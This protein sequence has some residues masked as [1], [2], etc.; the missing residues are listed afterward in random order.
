[1]F[2]LLACNVKCRPGTCSLK[3][4]LKIYYNSLSLLSPQEVTE[5]GLCS[6]VILKLFCLTRVKPQ[7]RIRGESQTSIVA[8]QDELQTQQN[9][10]SYAI[11]STFRS[12]LHNHLRME[13]NNN[14]ENRQQMTQGTKVQLD[15]VPMLAYVMRYL[16]TPEFVAL[17]A[18]AISHRVKQTLTASRAVQGAPVCVL[19]APQKNVERAIQHPHESGEIPVCIS[20]G[21]YVGRYATTGLST[22]AVRS[23]RLG[24]LLY[25][26]SPS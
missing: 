4:V 13:T 10:N 16:V 24:T 23:A 21:L 22:L 5:P 11:T 19:N 26:V 7:S 9:Q 2:I 18:T 15:Y 17:H 1:M 3:V 8:E 6:S 12:T 14:K 25:T 20:N